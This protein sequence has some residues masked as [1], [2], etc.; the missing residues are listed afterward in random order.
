L[1]INKCAVS[2]SAPNNVS[3]ILSSIFPL[4]AIVRSVPSP[5][6]FSPSS[7]NVNPTFAGILMSVVAVKLI[8]VPLL[9]VK[10]VPS[11]VIDSPPVSKKYK[12]F[13]P[14]ILTSPATSSNSSGSVTPIPIFPPLNIVIFSVGDASFAPVQKDKLAAPSVSVLDS[15]TAATLAANSVVVVASAT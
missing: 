4:E 5:S 6:I 11:L 2:L 13:E 14:E 12:V 9:R 8:S 15:L 7:P 3:P 1:V 10:S